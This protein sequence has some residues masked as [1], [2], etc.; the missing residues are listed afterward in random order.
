[1]RRLSVLF[2]CLL[3]SATFADLVKVGSGAYRR[4]LPPGADGKP[5]RQVEAS[6]LLSE[7]LTRPAPTSDW[8]SSLVW[9]MHSPHSQP[10]FPHP[11][12][13]QAH[14]EGLG[15][16]YTRQ[17]TVSHHE[18]DGKIFQR[19]T[20]YRYPYRESIVVGLKGMKAKETR[21]DAYSAWM[22]TALWQDGAD[23]L[24]ATFGHGSPFVFFESDSD[25]PLHIRLTAAKVDRHREP[26]D[27]FVYEWRGITGAH[28]GKPGR[29]QLAVNA[30]KQVG[31]GSKARLVYDFDGDGK[32]DRIETFALFATDPVPA[33]WERYSS[34]KQ[35][36]DRG[37]TQG[38]GQHFENGSVRLEFWKCF[39]EGSVQL[40]LADS[41]VFL[42]LAEGER[43]FDGAEFATVGG[44]DKPPAA[45]LVTFRKGSVLGLRLNGSDFA[46]FAPEGIEWGVTVGDRIDT[47][48]AKTKYLSV[49]ALPDASE[50]TIM[51]F[52]DYAYSI[53]RD[54][55]LRYRYDPASGQVETTFSAF[56][57][58]RESF[59]RGT[60]FAL[61]RHQ[62]LHLPDAA[63][64]P[65]SY[66]SPRGE[67]RL[68]AGREFTT[69]TP[70]LGVLPAL[71]NR[72]ADSAALKVSLDADFARIRSRKAP[73]E[74]SDTYWNGKEFGKFCE[75][76][77]IAEQLG[78]DTV[79]DAL[80]AMLKSRLEDWFDGQAPH[81][82]YYDSRWSTLTGYPDSYGSGEQLNDHHF[83]YSYFIK[84]AATIAQ[85][86]PDWV[87][88][89]RYGGMIELLIRDCASP[90]PADPLFPW[91]RNFDPYAGHS[92]AAGHAGFA[93]GNNQESS[94]ESM[95]FATAL[96]L[97]GQATG[98]QDL[99]D[100]GIYWHSTEAEAIR[101]Y[102]F[103]NDG[104]V[105]PDGYGH[106]CVGMVWGDGGTYGT[107][108]TAN[109]EEIHGINY[110]PL[111]GGSLY[112]GRSPDYVRRN[113]ADLVRSNLN[114]HEAFP[115][116]GAE[117]DRWQDIIFGYRALVDPDRAAASLQQLGPDYAAEFGETHTH[118]RQWIGALQELGQVAAD[119]RA[120]HPTALAFHKDG[121]KSYVIYNPGAA[122]L[123]R[124]SDGARIL[125][126]PGLTRN[127]R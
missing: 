41:R 47:L 44:S 95:N 78:R 89:E 116:S 16:G 38:K 72:S 74:R 22:V 49:A 17:P 125:A 126:Q 75:L 18:K 3:A 56:T 32:T 42:P 12:A 80:L 109:P 9:P 111:N 5:R 43:R 25:R 71:P 76:I 99:R 103:D 11:L 19:G 122:K 59:D 35:A 29:I 98:R 108:W 34:E 65:Y 37:L 110:L 68:L 120:D 6:P 93:S 85:Y 62:H 50:A 106:S 39:G 20:S 10:M 23:E 102:W 121:A 84:A 69:Q 14:A 96:V 119:I 33:S 30:G 24:R 57:E 87:K 97:Y 127:S 13:V 112:L 88:P 123:V 40:K 67:M 51:W 117:F 1:M 73:F 46:I 100:L 79:R 2:A 7:R 77:Q 66:Q 92:W 36:L 54:S 86:D 45:G 52:R 105:F 60:L 104:A 83:H 91:L 53:P 70:F 107:W 124:F 48:R 21:L 94:S 64:S 15:I 55:R 4:D 113:L 118:T 63:F 27:P 8:C 90:D 58:A 114:F 101:H 31:I 26:V 115:G 82:F 81:F 61:Y 28:L